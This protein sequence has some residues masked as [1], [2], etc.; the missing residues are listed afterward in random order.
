MVR[1]LGVSVRDFTEQEQL[2][3][4]EHEE[5]RDKILKLENA[6]ENV[7]SRFGRGVINRGIILTDEHMKEMNIA[8]DVGALANEKVNGTVNLF[9]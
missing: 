3:F 2:N 4:C 8:N 5:K 7:R 6:I 1:G 9:E